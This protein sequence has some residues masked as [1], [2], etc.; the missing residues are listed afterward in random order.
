MATN[1]EIIKPPEEVI[2][3]LHNDFTNNT[4]RIYRIDRDKVP[5]TFIQ[6]N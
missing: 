3:Q 5:R 6:P 1:K 4:V 2:E